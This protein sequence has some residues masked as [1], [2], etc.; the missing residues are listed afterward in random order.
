MATSLELPSK[1]KELLAY[2]IENGH[3]SSKSEAIRDSI[4]QQHSDILEKIESGDV[5]V[6]NDE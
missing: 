3:Y 2:L 6:T 5:R 1:L 4:R